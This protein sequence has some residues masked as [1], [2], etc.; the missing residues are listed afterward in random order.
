MNSAEPSHFSVSG[1]YIHLPVG[2]YTAQFRIMSF[3]I[4][5]ISCGHVD[6]CRDCGDTIVIEKE[7]SPLGLKAKSGLIEL[8][9]EVNTPGEYEFRIADYGRTKIKILGRYLKAYDDC[10]RIAASPQ[11]S[12]VFDEFFMKA[13]DRYQHMALFGAK[14]LNISDKLVLNMNGV[15]MHLQNMEDF[16][17]VDEVHVLNTYNFR[18]PNRCCVIDIGMNVG[19]STL[20]FARREHVERVYSFEPFE[21]PY[22]RALENISLNPDIAGKVH[23]HNF[24]LAGQNATKTVAYNENTTIGTSIHG[25][26][27]ENST[28]IEIKRASEALREIIDKSKADGLAIV[29]KMDCEGSEFEIFDDLSA[30][31]I[32]ADIHILM[33]EWHKWWAADK[34]DETLIKHLQDFGFA[35][36]NMTQLH[37][38]F[39]GMIYASKKVNGETK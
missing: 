34:T 28:T 17:I 21:A 3:G 6:V 14:V 38:Q 12:V 24:G 30:T 16:Q 22:Q 19:I 20:Y 18:T 39:A 10:L 26:D 31:R 36:F 9:F 37:D 27:G 29:I 5:P 32:L 33:I 35:V 1:P 11:S 15:N 2:R 8:D 4:S 13:Y 25:N 7:F 23:P